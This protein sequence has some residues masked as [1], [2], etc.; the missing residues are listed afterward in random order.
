MRNSLF[1]EA[2]D[3]QLIQERDWLLVQWL[4]FSSWQEWNFSLENIHGHQ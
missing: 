2:I 4:R 1:I 3:K